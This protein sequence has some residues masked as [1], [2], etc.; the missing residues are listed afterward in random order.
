MNYSKQTINAEQKNILANTHFTSI[1]KKVAK[2]IAKSGV[3]KA[4]TVIDKDGAVI[5]AT[6]SSA[7]NA[8][9]VVMY[10][11]VVSNEAGANVAVPLITHGTIDEKA[12]GNTY[13]AAVKTALPGILFV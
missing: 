9:G 13:N 4:G 1:S 5:E 10:D 2:S 6:A 8:I 3:I 7:P 11:V 12:T